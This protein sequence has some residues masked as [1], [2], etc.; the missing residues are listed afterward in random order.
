MKHSMALHFI[1]EVQYEIQANGW[2]SNVVNLGKAQSPLKSISQ[3]F[4]YS[5]QFTHFLACDT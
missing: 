1:I 5:S 3:G 4:P 2:D